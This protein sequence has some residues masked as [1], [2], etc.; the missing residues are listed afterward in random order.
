MGH[1]KHLTPNQRERIVIGVSNQRSLRELSRE[2]GV[3]PST[4]SRELA[5][6]GGMSGY[7]CVNAQ[8]RYERQRAN[9]VR[10][11]R[12]TEALISQIYECLQKR[13]SPE[14]AVCFQC[15][16]VS[17][18]TVYR[19][20]RTG[21]FPSDVFSFL[22]RRGRSP[23]RTGSMECPEMGKKESIENRPP[24]AEKRERIGDYECDTV[25]GRRNTGCIGT[26]VDRKS[27]FLFAVKLES[28]H[29]EPL[30]VAFVTA[31]EGE[32][33]HTLTFDNGTEFAMH[34]GIGKVLDAKCYFA[35]PGHPW[36]RATNENTN[37]L[38]RDFLPK[39]TSFLDLTQKGLD[40][41]V[42]K[43]NTR[44]RKTLG[45]RTPLQVFEEEKRRGQECCT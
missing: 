35:N 20:I 21:A 16:P 4:I 5:R 17:T 32:P 7:S 26:I 37:G 22:R 2:I 45:W 12:L 8:T 34:L 29:S 11:H 30:A 19:G 24:E 18:T 9:C 38:I 25:L 39:G 1:Y 43:L 28:R 23:R 27:R 44:P 6:N 36:E 41:I 14:Q 15:L 33:C 31:L 13:W 3:H 10:R 40:D 42:Y